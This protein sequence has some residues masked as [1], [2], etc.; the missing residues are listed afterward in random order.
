MY[1]TRRGFTLIEL[2]LVIAIIGIFSA[3]VVAMLSSAR[4]QARDASRK[5]M[6]RQIKTALEIYYN[7]NLRY[8]QTGVGVS[9]VSISDVGANTLNSFLVPQGMPK[10]IAYDQTNVADAAYLSDSATPNSYV[11]N[12]TTEKPSTTTPS[13]VY[14]CKMGIGTLV[15]TYYP[16]VPLCR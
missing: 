4:E 16:G 14:S 8:P 5:E 7:S 6:A 1:K 11:L 10:N 9:I 3:I 13:V 15:N 2:L 12:I